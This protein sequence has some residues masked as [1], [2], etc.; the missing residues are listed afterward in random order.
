MWLILENK[1]CLCRHGC[2]EKLMW[3]LD[4][5]LVRDVTAALRKNDV[6]HVETKFVCEVTAALRN[7][8]GL[9]WKQNLSVTSWVRCEIDVV[10]VG[11]TICP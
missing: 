8:C 2:A 11:N 6:V 3:F 9:C 7:L 5:K 1:I 10:Y 4:I